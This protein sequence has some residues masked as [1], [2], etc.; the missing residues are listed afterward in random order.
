[1]GFLYSRPPTSL[2]V[3]LESCRLHLDGRSAPD[4]AA[5]AAGYAAG[6]PASCMHR[7]LPARSL[8]F[9]MSVLVTA[10]ML[11]NTPA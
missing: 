6:R 8:G 7:P 3:L 4:S 5:A 11:Q 1:V 2:Q 10:H 9:R